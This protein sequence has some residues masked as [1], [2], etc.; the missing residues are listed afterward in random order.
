MVRNSLGWGACLLAGVLALACPVVRPGRASA[1]EPS[2]AGVPEA[3]VVFLKPTQRD[4]HAAPIRQG[5]AL[6]GGGA[7]TVLQPAP[8][9]LIITLTGAAAAKANPCKPSVASLEA[10]VEQQFEVVFPAG[11]KPAH[12]ILE[13]RVLGLLR[14]EGHKSDSAELVEATAAVHHGPQTLVGLNFPSKSVNGREALALNLAA[15]PACVPVGPGCLSLH[16]SLHITASQG[17]SLC[18]HISSAE[19]A[20]PPALPP[21]WIHSPDPFGGVDRSGLGFQVTV[22]VEPAPKAP[23]AQPVAAQE[24]VGKVN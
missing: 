18:P 2:K 7:V 13:G 24:P 23:P 10:A 22:R 5:S 17:R 11:F 4:G 21:T 14:S 15:G 19:F 9:T 6:T 3:P 1:A 12:L 20:P 16:V 8:D